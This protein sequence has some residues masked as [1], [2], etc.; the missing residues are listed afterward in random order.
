MNEISFDGQV[1]VI[2]GAG[3]GLGRTYAMEIARRGGKVVVNDLGGSIRGTDGSPTMAD[4]VV[5]EI[6]SAGGQAVANYDTVATKE[7]GGKIVQAALDTFGRIDVL[8]NNAGNIRNDWVVNVREEDF[9]SQIATHLLGSFYTTQAALPHM[10]KQKYGR[11]VFT[12]SAAGMLGNRGQMSYGA[13]KGGVTALMNVVSLEAERHGILCNA[14]QPN[15]MNRFGPEMEKVMD[16]EAATRF[17][18]VIPP[19]GETMAAEFTTPLMVYLASN[20]CR[21][22]HSIYSSLGGRFAR[23][24][25]GITE[26][27]E[28]SKNAPSTA[29]D[30]A[31][32]IDEIRDE[33]R[34]FIIPS[35]LINE[36]ELVLSRRAEN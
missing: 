22:T 19:L 12:T 30:I 4:Q 8:I 23:V 17:G 36:F 25:I 24:F 26:G 14:V 29:E 2:T 5:A 16:D 21:S 28:G 15:A 34:G 33:T 27:W 18:T 31:A 7:G 6:T 10:A 32:H 20:A 11:I 13:A 35:D 1:V 3:G 9:Q